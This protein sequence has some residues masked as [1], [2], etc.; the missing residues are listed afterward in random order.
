MLAIIFPEPDRFA[1]KDVPQPTANAGQV[2]VRVKAT[3]ICA[4]DVKIWHGQVPFVTFPHIPGH[5]FGGEIVLD[6]DH[7]AFTD[8]VG[9]AL[10]AFERAG[11]VRG[12][13]NV[14]VVGPGALGLLAVQLARALGAGQVIVVGVAGDEKRLAL[15]REMGADTAV[16]AV[17]GSD[18]VQVVRD[19]TGG[20]GADLVI[21]FAG[22]PTPV[23]NP[24]KWPAAVGVSS[25]V[26][27]PAR[28]GGWTLI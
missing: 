25:W 22:P 24:W 26:G 4:T 9:I 7:A 19:L 17:E 11:G 20:L 13:E 10:W 28:V 16:T 27:L 18:P 5:E 1:V 12:G 3:T 14:A 6:C 2:V 15:A 21:E 8:T 23:A